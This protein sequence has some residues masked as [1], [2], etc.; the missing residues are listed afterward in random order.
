MQT[1]TLQVCEE[2]SP[3][4]RGRE[5]NTSVSSLTTGGCR[6]SDLV[7]LNSSSDPIIHKVRM[8]RRLQE[9][10]GVED[11]VNVV[12][13]VKDGVGYDRL[14]SSDASRQQRQR[15]G[16]RERRLQLLHRELLHS[17]HKA[18]GAH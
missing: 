15:G 16:Q 1:K 8:R 18:D 5:R 6:L 12:A 14:G 2:R 3:K 11:V 7:C 10:D 9:G 4:E 13:E 17:E